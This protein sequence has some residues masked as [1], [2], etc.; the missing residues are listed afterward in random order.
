MNCIIL[1]LHYLP[2]IEYFCEI[3]HADEIFIEAQESF[4]KQ[5]F[6]SRSKILTSNKVMD[7]NV[8]VIGG[9]KHIPIKEVKIDYSQSWLKQHIRAIISAYGKAPFFEHYWDYLLPVF[10]KKP[11]YLFQ[12]N[13]ELLTVC[14]KL[15]GISK[16]LYF[17]E[18]YQKI[19][20][21]N[22]LDLRSIYSPKNHEMPK[23]QYSYYQLFGNNFVENMSILDLLFSVGP[24]SKHLLKSAARTKKV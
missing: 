15:I 21:D 5:T 11:A 7:L 8:P 14:L 12:L 24:E 6:R 16:K 10:E 20:A 17:T 22:Q 18:S 2:T 9:R 4:Q 1:D 13:Q 23:W 19:L 3:V